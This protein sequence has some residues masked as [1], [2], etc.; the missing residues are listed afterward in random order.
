MG[1]LFLP[2][3][4]EAGASWFDL[5]VVCTRR[6]LSGSGEILLI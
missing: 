1:R 6:M 2:T 3:V 4:V 5:P